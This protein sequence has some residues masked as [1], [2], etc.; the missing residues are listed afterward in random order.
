[1]N[2]KYILKIAFIASLFL[3]AFILIT[4]L[5]FPNSRLS[6]INAWND[7]MLTFLFRLFARY[8]FWL[9]VSFF[10][11]IFT[12]EVRQSSTEVE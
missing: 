1:M 10:T 5:I 8:I 12:K 9:V 7:G 6:W 2:K 4:D 3:F 11:V